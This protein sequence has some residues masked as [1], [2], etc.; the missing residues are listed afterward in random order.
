MS[1]TI[2][3]CAESISPRNRHLPATPHIVHVRFDSFVLDCEP[4]QT[5]RF[6]IRVKPV[7]TRELRTILQS[8]TPA[9]DPDSNHG[10]YLNF[11]G[12]ALLQQDFPGTLRRLQLAILKHSSV[13]VSVGAAKSRVAAAV[14]SR[15]AKPGE[16]RIV[17][18]DAEP[19][20]LAPLPIEVLHGMNGMDPGDLRNRGIATL[21]ALQRVPRPALASIYGDELAAQVWRNS[22]GLDSITPLRPV[23][24]SGW[25]WLRLAA[26]NH[27]AAL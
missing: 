14:A 8:F 9:I 16:L 19:S 3:I 2:A 25:S 6:R 7:A 4:G 1:A 27:V 15:I 22:R 20:F 18:V 13:I 26:E 10:F 5:P 21:A 17:A 23:A 11:F 12:S 24:T